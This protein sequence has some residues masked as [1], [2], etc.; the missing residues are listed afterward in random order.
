MATRRRDAFPGKDKATPSPQTGTAKLRGAV[1]QISKS[2]KVSTAPQKQTRKPVSTA[3]RT[4]TTDVPK[5]QTRKPASSTTASKPAQTRTRSLDNKAVTPTQKTR[6][7]A[8]TTAAAP[9][10][11]SLPVK[12]V[13]AP[14]P[15]PVKKWKPVAEEGKRRLSGTEEGKR[16]LSTTSV[17][18]GRRSSTGIK[19]ESRNSASG[20]K[21]QQITSLNL[22]KVEDLSMYCVPEPEMRLQDIE[23]SYLAEAEEKTVQS[24]SDFEKGIDALAREEGQVPLNFAKIEDVINHADPTVVIAES[25][26]V[27]EQQKTLVDIKTQELENKNNV[28]ES[29]SKLELEHDIKETNSCNKVEKFADNSHEEAREK[30]VKVV[31]VATEEQAAVVSKADESKEIEPAMEKKQENS[32][33]QKQQERTHGKYDSPVSNDV[34]EETAS[35]LREQR[36]NKV[37]A[38]A[39]AF[40]TVISLQEK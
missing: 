16:R 17:G 15:A 10:S 8:T 27:S 39:G 6:V 37:R 20:T 24:L 7:S 30:D 9:R 40:E 11:S 2:S 21:E 14:K 1:N 4:P 22:D 26:T 38:L 19:K 18:N 12:A 25:S 3:S 34:I 32:V 31:E 28:Y 23:Y 5:F 35:K 13:A 33:P 29:S 36:K